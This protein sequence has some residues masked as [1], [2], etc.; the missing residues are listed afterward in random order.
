MISGARCA[1][2][3]RTV[4]ALSSSMMLSAVA[5]CAEPAD[6]SRVVSLDE[7][8][9]EG[10]DALYRRNMDGSLTIDVAGMSDYIRTLGE[11]DPVKYVLMLPGVH[12]SDDYASGF[13]VEGFNYS[14]SLVEMDGAPV[15]FPY[16]FGGIFSLLNPRYFRKVGFSRVFPA[17][18]SSPRLGG[19]LV[20]SSPDRVA[21]HAGGALSVGIISSGLSAQV[22]VGTKWQ[23]SV[24][25]RLSYL[26]ELMEPFLKNK[27]SEYRYDLGDWNASV[28]YAP[29]GNNVLKANFSGNSDHL[30]YFDHRYLNDTRVNWGNRVASLQ[31]KHT[32]PG[33]GA[34]VSAWW[35]SLRSTLTVGMSGLDASM[36]SGISQYGARGV[37]FF[38]APRGHAYRWSVGAAASFSQIS[39]AAVESSWILVGSMDAG[40]DRAWESSVHARLET[41][42]GD[43]M[44]I[45][46]RFG[47]ALY[48]LGDY[49]RFFPSVLVVPELA[50]GRNLFRA[51]LSVQPQFFHQV[52]FSEIGLASNFWIGSRQEAPVE[53]AYGLSLEWTREWGNG[54]ES[55]V[56]PYFKWI[57][58]ES[59]YGGGVFDLLE[60]N[61]SPYRHLLTGSGYNVGADF[62]FRRTSGSVTGWVSY[63]FGLARRRYS[64]HPDVWVPSTHE[65]LNVVKAF[66]AWRINPHWQLG[67]SFN[68]FTGRPITPVSEVY[69]FANNVILNYGTRNSSRLPDYHRLDLSA[70]YS[71]RTSG[72]F[73]LRH[74]VNVSL[75]NA[76][77]HQNVEFTHFRYN[78]EEGYLYQ[79]YSPSL[80]R[81]LPSLSYTVEML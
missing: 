79:K 50:H 35:S 77:G 51:S 34:Q 4:M 23:I 52:G 53:K 73:P 26:N 8:V 61:Y 29:D 31:W 19:R 38:P 46:T 55:A 44:R 13:S 1:E 47:V 18:D 41:G 9:V 17:L 12:A 65:L 16:H 27:E 43:I 25:G 36:R 81:F 3:R 49:R 30:G 66:V 37:L 54:F 15:F 76:Y 22:P 48:G 42:I 2:W 63:S 68:Y 11:A 5:Y 10:G 14:Q 58:D 62:T 39:P 33:A 69:V 75:L 32:G 72:R 74:S 40:K 7:F 24:A 67:A 21:S 56:N 28:L 70:T 71:F 78:A 59:D 45:D 57:D 6:T 20:A 64:D 80:F 60:E